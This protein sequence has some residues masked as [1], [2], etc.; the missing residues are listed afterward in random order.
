MR[1]MQ[2]RLFIDRGYDR[3]KKKWQSPS[4]KTIAGTLKKNNGRTNFK[5][6]YRKGFAVSC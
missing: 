1:D 2:A 4:Q 3:N 5:K 6:R